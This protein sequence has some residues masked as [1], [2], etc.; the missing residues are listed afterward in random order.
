MFQSCACGTCTSKLQ[1]EQCFKHALVR[2]CTCLFPSEE[3]FCGQIHLPHAT[4]SHAQSSTVCLH[5]L[6]TLHS[7]ISSRDTRGSRFR[8]C[9]RETFHHVSFLAAPDTDHRHMLSLSHLPSQSYSHPLLHTRACCPTI[10]HKNTAMT[11]RGVAVPRISNL[12]Q[13]T[14]PKGS[15]STGILR[16]E[17]QDQILGRIM[18]HDNQSPITEDMGEFGK[19]GGESLSYNQSLLRFSRKHC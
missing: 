2:S 9:V 5:N 4:F 15:S 19:I 11:H 8:G 1:F 17:H 7:H 18:G 10:L 13:S 3:C 12:P 6:P 16:F 14:S